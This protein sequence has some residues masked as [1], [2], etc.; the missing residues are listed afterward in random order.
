[1][2]DTLT[3]K[4][5]FLSVFNKLVIDNISSARIQHTLNTAVAAEDPNG[6]PVYRTEITLEDMQTSTY[7]E[8][9]HYQLEGGSEQGAVWYKITGLR[10]KNETTSKEYNDL[11]MLMM[12]RSEKIVL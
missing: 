5:S 12:D 3:V 9:V 7:T 10:L 2:A 6:T 11:S 8:N 4:N 1:M